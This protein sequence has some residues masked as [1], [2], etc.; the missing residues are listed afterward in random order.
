MKKKG[1]RFHKKNTAYIDKPTKTKA[2]TA[3]MNQTAL[4]KLFQLL[5]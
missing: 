4:T 3:A 1:S 2:E 5:S